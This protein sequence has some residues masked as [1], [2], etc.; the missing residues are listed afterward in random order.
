[1]DEI[2]YQHF[3]QKLNENDRHALSEFLL[4]HFLDAFTLTKMQPEGSFPDEMTRPLASLFVDYEASII[5]K[6]Y[7]QQSRV[8][9]NQRFLGFHGPP[10]LADGD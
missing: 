3:S 5:G 9:E 7:L 2:Q 1:M 10:T 4:E 8:E 6:V